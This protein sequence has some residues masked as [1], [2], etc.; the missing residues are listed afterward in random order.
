MDIVFLFAVYSDIE[1]SETATLVV[2]VFTWTSFFVLQFIHTLNFQ[3][4]R[5]MLF[6]FLR[7][8]RFSFCSLFRHWNFKNE[9]L[10]SLYDNAT[11]TYFFMH[12][13]EPRREKIGF[14]HMRKQ[15]TQISF[16]V[17]AKLI[18]AFVFAIRIGQSLYYLHPK[19]QA[20]SHLLWLYRPVCVGPGR[21]PRRPVFSQRGSF[22]DSK[23]VSRRKTK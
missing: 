10:Q 22:S 18:I 3:K 6:Q 19:L 2:S 14:L 23:T 20:S 1:F 4:Q 5:L 16:A 21:K 13:F 15:K 7:G 11:Q 9:I 17:T 8:Y 12:L